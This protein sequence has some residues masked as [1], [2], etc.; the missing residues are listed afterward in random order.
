MEVKARRKAE[1]KG[2]EMFGKEIDRQSR[3][4]PVLLAVA[5]ATAL[6]FTG[7]RGLSG[8]NNL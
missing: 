1:E 5:S 6:F 7:S 3:C 8:L 2:N 4:I